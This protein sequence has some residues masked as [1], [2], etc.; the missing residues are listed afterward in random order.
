MNGDV[1]LDT[2]IVEN[3]KF[4]LAKETQEANDSAKEKT[5]I[6]DGQQ[7]GKKLV[8]QAKQV[9]AMPLPLIETEQ[10]ANQKI[11][12]TVEA[13]REQIA[14]LW[15]ETLKRSPEIEFVM[16]KLMPN[17]HPGHATNMAVRL[18]STVVYGAMNVGG[19]A[20]GGGVGT[21]AMYG[22]GG[23]TLINLL[24]QTDSKLTK[25]AKLSETESIQL[26]TIVRTLA[27]R[28]VD[29]HRCYKMHLLAFNQANNDL[30]ELGNMVAA[31]KSVQDPSKQVEMEY[32]LRKAK[33]DVELEKHQVTRY[34]QS[35]VD[36]AGLEAVA[37]L[38]NQIE[39]EQSKIEQLSPGSVGTNNLLTPAE[40]SSAFKAPSANTSSQAEPTAEPGK[41]N[42]D[43]ISQEERTLKTSKP[44]P[45]ASKAIPDFNRAL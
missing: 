13:E 40:D 19:M 24:N 10:E 32:T 7:V 37:K 30:N 23:S 21:Q 36:M 35:L 31:A 28:L 14:N 33:R 34:R 42:A 41:D 38:D 29:D 27:N 4:P 20:M 11:D 3:A 1:E 2:S 6:V 12:Q 15:E 45:I 26:F 44:L 25:M 16:N 8:E 18:L 39:Y 17:S 5:S 22:L 9:N 43:L